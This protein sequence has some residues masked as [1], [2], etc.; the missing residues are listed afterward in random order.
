MN[1]VIKNLEN[2]YI[3]KMKIL[4]YCSYPTQTNG[5]ARIGQ[6]ITNYL[7]SFENVELYYFG[8][9]ASENTTIHRFIHPRI[10]LINVFQE[11][12]SKNPYGDDLIMPK[13]QEIQPDVI[14]LYNDIM[15]LSRMIQ[16]INTIQSDMKKFK[17]YTYIDLVYPFENSEMISFIDKSTDKFF[18]FSE[19]W[20]ENLIE[21]GIHPSKIFIFHHGLDTA[22]IHKI[23]Q[24]EARQFLGLPPNDFI[25]LNLNRNTHRKA[26]DITIQAFILLLKKYNGNPKIKLYLTR[27]SES[28]SYPLLEILKIECIKNGFNHDDV[29]K[30]NILSNQRLLNDNE[31]NYLYNSCDVGINTCFGEGFGLCNMEHA[32]V[33]KPQVITKT[34]G[35]KDI[36]SEGHVQLIIPCSRFYNFTSLEKSGG[37]LEIGSAKDFADGL[38]YYYT[39]KEK[40]LED[41]KHYEKVIPIK[42]DWNKILKEFYENHI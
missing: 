37:Y 29:L 18:V 6:N 14:F 19:C 38:D 41:G 25:I 31:I 35:L 36:F 16:Q 11:S 24:I 7:A 5:Y 20:K 32:S 42:Y 1:D 13:I 8:I 34:G 21:I 10:K 4:F 28:S 2:K 17:I 26:I 39:N 12:P 23:N 27:T 3:Y 15:V 22:K 9:T 40:C 30:N 33:G